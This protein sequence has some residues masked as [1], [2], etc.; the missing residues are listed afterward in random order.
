MPAPKHDTIY[1]IFQNKH[2]SSY[3]I[4]HHL[5][6]NIKIII[7]RNH[8]KSP[9]SN[10]IY[11]YIVTIEQVNKIIQKNHIIT[12]EQ[13]CKMKHTPGAFTTSQMV[14]HNIQTVYTTHNSG[15]FIRNKLVQY[16]KANI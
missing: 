14:H 15:A 12:M 5:F 6:E 16:H 3:Q 8:F 2:P 11:I 1:Q 7:C 4:Q 10:I 13:I 9:A